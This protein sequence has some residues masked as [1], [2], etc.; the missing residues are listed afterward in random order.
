[1]LVTAIKDH[2]LLRF[3]QGDQFTIQGVK[4]LKCGCVLFDVGIRHAG[5]NVHGA[6]EHGSEY[7]SE[8][9]GW[10]ASYMFTPTAEIEQAVQEIVSHVQGH[11]IETKVYT[12]EQWRTINGTIHST[13]KET[14]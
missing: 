4:Y 8:E 14:S 13:H 5:F 3:K 11:Y 7:C 10:Y 1:M 9:I 6:C 12:Q 2:S